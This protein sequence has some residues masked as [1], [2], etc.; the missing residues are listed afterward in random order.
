MQTQTY[1]APIKPGCAFTKGPGYSLVIV[2]HL[3]AKGE[4]RFLIGQESYYVK[5]QS[6]KLFREIPDTEKTTPDRLAY[7][8]KNANFT[9]LPTA[10]VVLRT[11]NNKKWKYT[12]QL[13]DTNSSY[14]F[15]KGRGLDEKETSDAIAK[16]EFFEEVGYQLQ[17]SKLLCKSCVRNPATN[18][19]CVV[20]HYEVDDKERAD[21]EAAYAK[22]SSDR[23]GE[24]F[25]VRF[26]TEAEIKLLK[27]NEISTQAIDSFATDFAQSEIKGVGGKLPKGGELVPVTGQAK[28]GGK[29]KTRRKSKRQTRKH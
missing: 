25:A 9:K 8:K 14:G 13:A 27:K 17:D 19:Q 6:G 18:K 16:R 28:Q 2:H 20:F 10:Q 7:A 3:D 22:K 11:Q 29:R 24:L 1:R 12:L 15:P 26:L 23:V 4:R 21:I 5:S